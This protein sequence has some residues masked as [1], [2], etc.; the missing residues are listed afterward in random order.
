[1]PADAAVAA[2]HQRAAELARE[3][4]VLVARMGALDSDIATLR[5]AADI[6]DG[7]PVPAKP[8]RAAKPTAGVLLQRGEVPKAVL[9]V[10]RDAPH[11]LTAIELSTAV[12]ARLGH[13]GGALPEV[14]F[15][16]K[17]TTAVWAHVQRGTLRRIEVPGGSMRWEVAR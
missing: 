7:K 12:L 14:K 15:T 5:R 10:L 3:R 8:L 9:E 2:L 17:V 1:M 11:P 13:P 4:A 6:L 16:S